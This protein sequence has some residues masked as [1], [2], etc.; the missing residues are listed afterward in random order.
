MTAKVVLNPYSNR[1]NAQ[2]RWPEAEAALK[3]AGVDFEMVIS[4]RRGHVTD[5]VEQAARDGFSPIIAAGGDG[6][7][8]DAVNGLARAAKSADEP[9]GPF[10]IIPLGSA[11]DLVFNLGLSTDL[12][13]AAK[14]IA[15][16]KTKA[17]DL[18]KCNDRYFANNSACGL[19]PYVTTKHERIHWIKGMARYLVAAVWAIM[20]KPEWQGEV[21]W[22]DGEYKGPLSLVS[23][24]NGRRTGGFFMTPHADPFDGKLT[25]AFGYRNTR[26]GLFGALPRA[27]NEGEKSYVYMD[28]MREVH[29]KKISIHLDHPSPAHTDGELFSEYVQSLKYEIFPKRLQILML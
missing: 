26:M 20:D 8:G 12:K 2:A 11:N 19:E 29:S 14:G 6:T 28:G 23:V 24:G 10:G 5:L 17:V 1:W 15:A 27:F 9:L 13:E 21:K 22:D 3:A 25:L 7:I 16:G 18:C 4:E